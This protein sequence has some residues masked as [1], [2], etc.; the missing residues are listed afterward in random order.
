MTGKTG[1]SPAYRIKE[2]SM[3]LIL[4]DGSPAPQEVLYQALHD[5][6]AEVRVCAAVALARLG[7]LSPGVIDPLFDAADWRRDP[8]AGD[9]ARHG[10][11]ELGRTNAAIVERLLAA[12]AQ[13]E[14][15]IT[16]VAQCLGEI[17]QATPAV[18]DGLLA[19]VQRNQGS[20][21][22]DV[23]SAIDTLLLLGYTDDSLLDQLF[24][25]YQRGDVFV[26]IVAVRALAW[27]KEPAPKVID[28][29]LAALQQGTDEASAAARTLAQLGVDQPRVVAALV[30]ASGA[31]SAQVRG[32]AL[33]ALSV[34]ATPRPA[35]VNIFYEALEDSEW[36]V[37]VHAIEGLGKLGSATPEVLDRL[38]SLL[39]TT[40]SASQR[41]TIA[42]VLAQLGFIDDAV[43]NAFLD[44]LH[45]NDA[46]VRERIVRS[47]WLLGNDNPLLLEPLEAALQDEA[48]MVRASAAAS[49]KQLGY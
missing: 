10:I 49:L 30:Q 45:S 37:R 44:E 46:S 36:F 8:D 11:V 2:Y 17:G 18:I 34:V 24:M 15:S 4:A 20:H 19:F 27:V 16:G 38:L 41:G 31:R 40:Q 21:S 29:L 43:T 47:W 6:D 26:R 13:N 25:L 9:R 33:G 35:I 3:E 48:E 39:T 23:V 22:Y 5:Q 1:G 7:D 32:A 28:L 14:R 12:L 42:I